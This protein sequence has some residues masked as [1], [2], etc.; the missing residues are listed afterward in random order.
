MSAAV[1]LA[2]A[3]LLAGCK[4]PDAN[5]ASDGR[6]ELRLF[7][8]LISSKQVEHYKWVEES[9]EASNPDVDVVFEQFPGSSLKDYEIKL[10]LR[11]SSG[12]SPDV[13]GVAESVAAELARLDL[14]APAPADVERL[15]Q[16]N[17]RNEMI[18]LAPYVDGTCY[19]V[20]SDAGPT[21]LYYNKA[22]LREAGMDPDQPPKT[23]D[24][25]VRMA[26]QLTKRSEDGTVERAGISLR[27]SGFKPGIAEKWFT[28][29]YS[30]GGVAFND[31]GSSARFNSDAG[32]KALDLY[33][34]ILFDRR[35]DSVELEG[36]QQGFGQGRSAMF[37]REVHVVRWLRETYPELEFG[38]AP[39][40]AEEASISAGGSY[41]FVVSNDSPHKDAAW[42]LVRYLMSDEVY[43]RYAEIG[44]IIP[45]T[46]SVAAQPKY[47]ERTL[48]LRAP[49]GGRDA[50]TS[51]ARYQRHSVGQSEKEKR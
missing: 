44:G 12:R 9:F 6:A 40:P 15:V 28:F 14:L 8:L 32:R 26:D 45:A 11:F 39:I 37:I 3:M 49:L 50:R 48:L 29:L 43:S 47:T 16:E 30:A 13:F 24:E 35:I 2:V 36:D 21:V 51:G 23:W 34:T 41:V 42:R 27:T 22:M 38:V 19:G 18:R 20:V 5:S 4:R 1:C 10:R 33:Q 31:E 7:L 25:L 17:S 46:R